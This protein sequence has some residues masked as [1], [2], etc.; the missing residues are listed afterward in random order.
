MRLKVDHRT[1]YR[2]ARPQRRLTQL[3]RMTPAGTDGQTVVD[4]RLHLD[5]DA[6]LREGRDGF[7]NRTTMLYIAGPISSLELEV[8]G[9]VLTSETD[10][11]LRGGIE[12][13]PAELFLRSTPLT[14]AADEIVVFAADAIGSTSDPIERTHRL[15]VAVH[16]RFAETGG[17]P[18]A[19]RTAAD[20]FAQGSAD[21]RDRAQILLSALRSVGLPARYVSGYHLAGP[22]ETHD[23]APHGWVE[24]HVARLGWIAF[25]P[26]TGLSADQGYVRVAAALDSYGAAPV[27]GS[28]L[29]IGAEELDV[30]VMVRPEG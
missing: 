12:T 11:I 18:D 8:V 28:R 30:D 24:V 17:P 2:F 15:N 10:G 5:C 1:T 14:P 27:A 22:A 26:S 7:G 13:L 19:T 9:E 6:R 4:W 21:A 16:A 29:G 20:A 3:L 25:D 23:P